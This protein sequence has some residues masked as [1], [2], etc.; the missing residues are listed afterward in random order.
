MSISMFD[1]LANLVTHLK[2]IREDQLMTLGQTVTHQLDLR[3]PQLIL[4]KF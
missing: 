1:A 2:D 4:P 3:A